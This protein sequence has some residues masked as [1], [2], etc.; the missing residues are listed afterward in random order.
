MQEPQPEIRYASRHDIRHYNNRLQFLVNLSN[1][2]ISLGT[3]MQYY[4]PQQGVRAETPV[5]YHPVDAYITWTVDQYQ[6]CLS[7]V[8][9]AVAS[10]QRQHDELSACVDAWARHNAEQQ[11]VPNVSSRVVSLISSCPVANDY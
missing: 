1:T 10:K 11:S 3:S 9:M 4:N 5:E 2:T 8:E 6:S 7:E